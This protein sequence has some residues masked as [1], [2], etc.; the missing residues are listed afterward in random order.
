MGGARITA[1]LI[2][3]GFANEIHLLV[4]PLVLDAATSLFGSATR[5]RSVD[6]RE[7]RRLPKGLPSL[8]YAI[9]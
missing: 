1:S 9:H 5:R 3:A 2:D 7:A 4:H 6:L 8:T